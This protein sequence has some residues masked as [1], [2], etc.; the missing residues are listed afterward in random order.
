MSRNC[1]VGLPSSRVLPQTRSA[2][3]SVLKWNLDA[4][5]RGTHPEVNHLGKPWPPGTRAAKIAGTRIAGPYFG[6]FSCW[7]G[8]MEAR[9]LAHCLDAR[10]YRCKLICDL[11]LAQRTLGLSYGDLNDNAAWRRFGDGGIADEADKSHWKNVEGYDRTRLFL[12]SMH[13]LN[14]GI[15]RDII[16]SILVDWLQSKQL[17]RH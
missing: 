9:V 8:D 7:Q 16:A 15:M 13:I 11:C 10:H 14:L 1:I 3:V 17:H 2:V 5:A 6:R 4:L 12:D